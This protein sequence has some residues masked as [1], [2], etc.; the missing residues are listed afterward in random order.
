MNPKNNL[1]NPIF[2]TGD[3][4]SDYLNYNN[5]KNP[6]INQEFS[7]P[8]LDAFDKF[9]TEDN[10]NNS[11]RNS[12]ASSVYN[13]FKSSSFVRSTPITPKQEYYQNNQ[14]FLNNQNYLKQNFTF[15]NN[16]NNDNSNN[17]NINHFDNSGI[18]DSFDNNS[19]HIKKLD[20]KTKILKKNLLFKTS[21]RA[22]TYMEEIKEKKLAMNRESA[23]KSR[24]KKKQYIEKLEKEYKLAK[25]ELE[26]I[27]KFNFINGNKNNFSPLDNIQNFK[28]EENNIIKNNLEKDNNIIFDFIKRQKE[29]VRIL[30]INQI[31]LITPIK[32]KIFQ[33]KYLKLQNIER[34]DDIATI[35]NKIEV[36]LFTI[37]ELYDIKTADNKKG[38]ICN[39]N[40]SM[41]YQIYS[42]YISLKTFVSEFE[43]IYSK[44]DV[45]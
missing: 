23:K 9:F 45:I 34:D 20:K 37:N 24:L 15:N 36:N 10:N 33:D 16:L 29:L 32:I 28:I 18:N 43:T 27:K 25:A 5:L 4:F 40:N 6:N 31:D 42:F 35:K 12:R 22:K 30:L 7:K 41:A 2:S 38:G 8:N 13:D 11:P 44:I 39:K 19:T 1:Q 21:K 3:I 17:F 14:I 26:T